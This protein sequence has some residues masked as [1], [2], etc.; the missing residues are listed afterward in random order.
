MFEA[1]RGYS[2]LWNNTIQTIFHNT[3]NE[4]SGKI[5]NR[6]KNNQDETWFKLEINWIL[7]GHL[8]LAGNSTC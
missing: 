6:W 7:P 8:N 4:Y 1:V 3:D 5:H 2:W